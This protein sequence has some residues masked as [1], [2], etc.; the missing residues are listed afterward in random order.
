MTTS[1]DARSATQTAT[2][3]DSP[4]PERYGQ[5]LFRAAS[6]ESDR[7][8]ALAAVFDQF[9][10]HHLATL[11]AGPGW[12]CLDVGSGVGTL[13]SWLAGQG[14]DV[15]AIDR[16]TS[17]LSDARKAGVRV[18][19]ADLLDDG[20]DPGLFDLVHARFVLVHLREREHVL[21]RL[22]SWVRPG[23]WLVVSDSA[24]LG[25]ATSPNDEY[26]RVMAALWRALAESIGTEIDYGR[27]YPAALSACGLGSLGASVDV[28]A[29]TA[30]SPA[31]SFWRLTLEECRAAI[32]ATGLV[33]D[34]AVERVLRYT[35][36]PGTWDLSL[37]M[38]TAWG[39][40]PTAGPPG[41]LAYG[42]TD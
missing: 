21:R 3:P 35:E 38:I 15:T 39:R 29:M 22:A 27:R 24:D 18:V 5:R 12:R 41:Q 25:T 31:A 2:E 30:G 6:R 23:G 26:R 42:R 8:L 28:P 33:D 13:A 37:A 1:A 34:D 9:S 40:K 17:F 10:H 20:F 7:L 32:V 4:G 11:G 14:A 19:E 36:A 16:D